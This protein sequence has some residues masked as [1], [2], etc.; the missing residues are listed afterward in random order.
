MDRFMRLPEARTSRG[1]S[2][3]A[4]YSDIKNGTCTAPVALGARSVGWPASEIEALN[5]ARIAGRTDDQIRELVRSLHAARK[6]AA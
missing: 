6:A 3:S 5:A 2:R 4:H 1:R